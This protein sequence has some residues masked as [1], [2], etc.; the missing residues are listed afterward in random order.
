VVATK[1]DHE[2]PGHECGKSDCP[3]RLSAAL[4]LPK[5]NGLPPQYRMLCDH[6]LGA[7]R[8][9]YCR[10]YDAAHISCPVKPQPSS[11]FCQQNESAHLLASPHDPPPSPQP[12][13]AG[14]P[15]PLP[16]SEVQHPPISFFSDGGC[17]TA[18]ADYSSGPPQAYHSHGWTVNANSVRRLL[19]TVESLVAAE[20][21][22]G[23][24]SCAMGNACPQAEWEQGLALMAAA[25]AQHCRTRSAAEILAFMRDGPD[26][27]RK[28][29]AEAVCDTPW[30]VET[31]PFS[32]AW[33]G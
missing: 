32:A 15:P 20:A 19:G 12:K 11:T 10:L 33:S 16:T 4:S 8:R 31:P 21:D 7:I 6:Q 26:D 17:F 13:F 22:E 24:D 5:G 3:V 29:R 2:Q 30:G 23:I 9:T 18:D 25:M 14:A 27:R 28:K 1:P